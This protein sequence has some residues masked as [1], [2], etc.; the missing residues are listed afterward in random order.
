MRHASA[1]DTR[2]RLNMAPTPPLENR[3]VG[4][5]RDPTMLRVDHKLFNG[6]AALRR[7]AVKVQSKAIQKRKGQARPG[8]TI[9]DRSNAIKE[10]GR[11]ITEQIN[12]EKETVNA[13]VRTFQIAIE[14]QK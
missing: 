3:H 6:Q 1:V 13:I 11:E 14:R 4:Y 5:A 8:D 10:T 12:A 7:K 2:D 9:P